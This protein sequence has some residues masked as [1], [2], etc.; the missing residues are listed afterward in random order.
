MQGIGIFYQ[1]SVEDLLGKSKLIKLRVDRVTEAYELLLKN[2][3]LSLSRNGDESLYV[4]MAGEQIPLVNALLVQQGFHVTEL[5]HQRD[6]LEDVFLR[7]TRE[8]RIQREPRTTDSANENA[9][10]WCRRSDSNRH[11]E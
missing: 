6:S 8:A 3:L 5:S 1:G 10:D 2:P 9:E 7:L 4:K 11:E